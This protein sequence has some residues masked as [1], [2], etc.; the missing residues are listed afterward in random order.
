[1]ICLMEKAE[2]Y[3]QMVMSTKECGFKAKE[4]DMVFWRRETVI[5]L[6]DIGL[7]IKE[8]AKEVTFSV[9]KTKFSKI[10]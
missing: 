7:M 1:M 10:F 3:F 8:K 6:K 2:W 9:K 4:A 5:T